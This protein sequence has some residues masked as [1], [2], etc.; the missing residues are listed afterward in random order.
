MPIFDLYS[1]RRKKKNGEM[2]DVYVYDEVPERL[3]VQLCQIMHDRIGSSSE[4][5]N[6][7][8]IGPKIVDTY[9][10]I[11]NILRR[12]YGVFRLVQTRGRDDDYYNELTNFILDTPETDLFL[13][14]IEIVCRAI[15]KITSDFDY[16]YEKNSKMKAKEAIEEVND[17]F[18]ESGIGYEY[19]NGEF[20]RI[21]SELVHTQIVKP[22][23]HLLNYPEFSGA[24]SE[25]LLAYE[26]YR[27]GNSKESINEALKAFESTMKIICERQGWNFSYTDNASRLIKVCFENKLIPSFWETHFSGVRATLE[28]GVPTGRNKLSGHGQGSSPVEV[29]DHIVGYVLHMTAAAIVFLVKAERELDRMS[30]G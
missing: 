20:I 7:Y 12:E 3:R 21:D 4:Y 9:M 24:Q 14:A 13:D 15:E 17:R 11:V 8:G 27:S 30:S 28:A 25:F 10:N 22:A 2:P 23:L 18:R 1:K 26:H 6:H 5:M 19:I 16:R 29:P